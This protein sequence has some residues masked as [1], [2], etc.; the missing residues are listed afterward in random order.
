MNHH[1]LARSI[2][3]LRAIVARHIVAKKRAYQVTRGSSKMR[4]R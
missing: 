4:F 3:S 2:A 1:A